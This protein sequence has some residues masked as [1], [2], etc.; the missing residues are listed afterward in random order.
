MHMGVD[1]DVLQAPER[2]D[3]NQVGRLAADPGQREEFRHGPGHAAAVPPD[4]NPAGFPHVPRLVP[5]EADRIN[6]PF[7]LLRRQLRHRP[8]VPRNAEQAGGGGGGHWISRL[9]REHRPDQDLERV[10][11]AVLGDLLDGGQCEMVDGA[12]Q[13]FHD[14][15]NRLC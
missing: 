13:R 7:D 15:V 12:R 2:E 4:E 10:F 11:A 8:R 1:A 3:E 6:E 14:A 5:V 9:R